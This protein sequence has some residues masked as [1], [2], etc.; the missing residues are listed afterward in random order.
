MMIRNKKDIE[1]MKKDCEVFL[2]EHNDLFFQWYSPLSKRLNSL[3]TPSCS[4]SQPR[5]QVSRN[6][7]E[8]FQK[9]NGFFGVEPTSRFYVYNKVPSVVTSQQNIKVK[10]DSRISRSRNRS[11]DF[12]LP[13]GDLRHQIELKRVLRKAK[14]ERSQPYPIPVVV[15]INGGTTV[16]GR[17]KYYPNCKNVSCSF[18]H[19]VVNCRLFPT[20]PHGRHC[21]Y[22]HP[23]CKFNQRCKNNFC[24][25]YHDPVPGQ[26]N[27][28]TFKTSGAKI[29]KFGLNCA[30]PG[31]PF[32]H[33]IIAV[34]DG[35]QLQP[36]AN[37]FAIPQERFDNLTLG[38]V[39][40]SDGFLP[41]GD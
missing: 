10:S 32:I 14:E 5:G 4:S 13:P 37:S 24:H 21:R 6:Q 8:K 35:T 19:P 38:D 36:A 27:T 12:D 16:P 2:G 15:Q 34:N 40:R 17:C 39:M 18:Q 31:C 9:D 23:L 28:Q 3:I 20:C 7:G 11:D 41:R 33:N 25:F 26:S 29:C 30:N 1:L 22:G